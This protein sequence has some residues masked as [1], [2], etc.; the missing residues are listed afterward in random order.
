ME[1]LIHISFSSS[2]N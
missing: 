2:W 1:V